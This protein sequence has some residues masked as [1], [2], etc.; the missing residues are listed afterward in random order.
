MLRY[1]YSIII[2]CFFIISNSCF[3]L[4]S[5]WSDNNEAKVR[6]ISP[7][8]HNNNEALITLGLEYKLLE[9]WKT[10]WKSPGDGGFPQDIDWSKST[11]IS[12]I[13]ILWPTPQEFEILGFTSI[14]YE[15]HV[16]FPIKINIEDIKKKTLLSF[17]INFLFCEDVCI[18]GNANLDLVIPPGLGEITNH[19]YQIEKSLSMIPSQEIQLSKIKN[20]SISANQNDKEVA[21]E[22][23][24]LKE[25]KFGKVKFYIDSNLGLPVV[26]P[27]ISYTFDKKQINAV[28]NY[29]KKNF[30]NNKFDINVILNENNLSWQFS[31][32]VEINQVSSNFTKLE[33]IFYILLISLLGGLILNVMPCVLPVLSLKIFSIMQNSN[34]NLLV[35]KSFLLTSSGIIF[36]FALLS[37]ILIF[38]K[39]IGLSI[40]WGIQFQQPIFLIFIATVLLFFSL[41]MFGLFEIK[42]PQ[43]VNLKIINNLNTRKNSID[44]FNGFFATLLATPCSAPFVG[45]AV[46]FAFTQSAA[47]MFSIFVF[48]GIGLSTP[49]LFIAIFPKLIKFIPKPGKWMI[50]IK[51]FLG[52][53]LFATFIWVILVLANHINF[54]NNYIFSDKDN[55]WQNISEVN[56]EKLISD[57]KIIFVD[58]TADWCATCQFNK[59]SVLNTKEIKNFFKK[60]KVVKVRGDWTKP[61]Q[62]IENYL[63]KYNKYGIPFNII[64]TPSRPKGIILSEILTKNQ[65]INSI[66]QN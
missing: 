59:I 51:Y 52:I 62:K 26:K 30:P 38:L 6:I 2:P 39:K 58:I 11:N 40:G 53:L 66:K 24:A 44:F 28:F 64:Y 17:K 45:T 42:I 63:R 8:S 61:D 5:E 27:N 31:K 60:N 7:N 35:R 9:G 4:E 18:P 46:T 56:I 37:I 29:D 34:E 13:E 22:I 65:I 54:K 33:S 1:I 3:A 50:K 25:E 12:N 57:K 41:N 55:D 23:L 43:F 20:F 21:I 32:T 10:Y 15:K 48:M 19:F 16:I 47:L 36:S 49:Y 14:G